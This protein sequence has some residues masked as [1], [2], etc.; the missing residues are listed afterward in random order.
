MSDDEVWLKKLPSRVERHE[1]LN[2]QGHE[3][4]LYPFAGWSTGTIPQDGIVVVI[5]FLIPPPDMSIRILRLEMTRTQ[6]AELA[7]GLDLVAQTP[8]VPPD[9]PS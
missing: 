2:K 7:K 1:A 9:K 3:T 6:C 8:H 5:E 4:P